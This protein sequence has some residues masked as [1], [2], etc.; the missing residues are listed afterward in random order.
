MAKIDSAIL[1]DAL[2]NVA[3]MICNDSPTVAN[4]DGMGAGEDATGAAATQHDLIGSE[5]HYNGGADVTNAYEA[6]YKATW[7]SIFSYGDLTSHVYQEVVICQDAANHLNKCL[8]R[9]TYDAITLGTGETLTFTVK[10]TL[11]QGS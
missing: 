1:N 9:F 3:R 5:T 4:Y 7:V 8:C 11:Q 2:E 10:C 6:S